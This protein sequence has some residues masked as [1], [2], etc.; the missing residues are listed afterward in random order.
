MWSTST[1][2]EYLV[3]SEHQPELCFWL[4]PLA[5]VKLR[6]K[7]FNTSENLSVRSKVHK[8]MRYYNLRLRGA[9]RAFRFMYEKLIARTHARSYSRYVGHSGKQ[10]REI[11]KSEA[12]KWQAIYISSSNIYL[13][14]YKTRQNCH[15]THTF[16]PVF[17]GRKF[18]EICLGDTAY[19]KQKIV[20]QVYRKKKL[21]YRHL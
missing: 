7:G 20:H 8:R 12:K 15:S 21:I 4:M 3:A 16:N 18:Q 14:R 5:A 17:P 13:W 19:H 10:W 9:K 1:N 11:G 2:T 6:R